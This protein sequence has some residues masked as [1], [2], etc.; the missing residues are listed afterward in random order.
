MVRLTEKQIY[1]LNNMNVA[2]QNAGLGDILEYLLDDVGGGGTGDG[3]AKVIKRSSFL[4]F[5]KIG[6]S[7]NLYIDTSVSTI[8]TWDD[9]SSE[10]YMVGS[11]IKNTIDSIEIINGGNADG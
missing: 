5:P 8:Y 11:S 1:D 2:A 4:E 6:S 3:G 7:K 10:Y 9:E